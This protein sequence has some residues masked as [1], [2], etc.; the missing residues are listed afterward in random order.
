MTC[1]SPGKVQVSDGQVSFAVNPNDDNFFLSLEGGLRHL[2]WL[3][4]MKERF[5]EKKGELKAICLD[6]LHEGEWLEPKQKRK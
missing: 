3:Q 4:G 1:S 6:Y 5:L 2:R